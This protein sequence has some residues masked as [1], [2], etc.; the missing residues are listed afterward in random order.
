ME[1]RLS[2]F[3]APPDKRDREGTF[4]NFFNRASQSG[5]NRSN[6]HN[7]LAAVIEPASAHL[8]LAWTRLQNNTLS[9]AR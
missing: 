1:L 3:R 2:D 6:C 9:F 8:L 7:R 4:V 5:G